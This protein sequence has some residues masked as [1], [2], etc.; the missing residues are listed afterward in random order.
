[1]STNLKQ[2]LIEDGFQEAWNIMETTQR[3][4]ILIGHTKVEEQAIALGQ[5]KI[6]G[7]PDLPKNI[8]WF[9]F[10]DRSMAFLAQINLSEVT[11][12]DLAHELPSNGILYFFHDLDAEGF[13]KEDK[14][15]FKVFYFEG[16]TS[17]L[18]RKSKPIDIGVDRKDSYQPSYFSSAKLSFEASLDVKETLME[19][20]GREIVRSVFDE[21]FTDSYIEFFEGKKITKLLGHP[22]I[23]QNPMEAD[24]EMALREKSSLTGNKIISDEERKQS[25]E[26]WKLLFQLDSIEE[27]DFLWVDLGKIYFW[28]KEEDLKNKNFE[29]AW[30]Q[31]QYS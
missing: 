9:K 21:D 10:N 1:M 29:K 2:K 5:S 4:S 27:L 31:V 8:D 20:Y 19:Y 26:D 15:R 7:C 12:Y 14:D 24:C 13:D 17:E 25:Y 16:D 30:F 3:N 22:N 23:I 18:E 6:G 28:I 11:Q